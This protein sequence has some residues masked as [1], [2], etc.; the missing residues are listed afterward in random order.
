MQGSRDTLPAPRCAYQQFGQRK[1][2][3]GMLGGD[4]GRQRGRQVLPPGRGGAQRHSRR[5]PG[6]VPA[7]AGLHQ[8]EARL[9]A[10]HP[11]PPGERLV[12]GLIA[13]LAVKGL[14]F[15]PVRSGLPA[16][17]FGERYARRGHDHLLR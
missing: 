11:E 16:V 9:A 4:L 7:V 2:P 10:P 13:D 3:A 15:V 6:Q 14:Q 8:D 1:G 17:E 12:I 5:K